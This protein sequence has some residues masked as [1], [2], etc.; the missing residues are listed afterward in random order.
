MMSPTRMRGLSELYGS[1][2]TTWTSRRERIGSSPRIREMSPPPNRMVPAVGVSC[3]RIS[4]DVVVLP[5]PDSPISPKVSPG[6]MAKST[7]STAFIQP[8]WRRSSIPVLTGKY[9]WRFS[10]SSNGAGIFLLRLLI[11]EPALRRPIRANLVIV[12][13]SGHALGHGM[14]AT[15]VEGAARGGLG[16]V[17]GVPRDRVELLLAAELWH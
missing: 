5:H 10:S 3:S 13:V 4:F 14:G 6:Q 15:R 12:R 9:F 8:I 1:W 11:Q 7:P 16:E 2:K 17:E